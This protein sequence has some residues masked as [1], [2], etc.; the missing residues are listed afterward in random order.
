M[1]TPKLPSVPRR[2]TP[3]LKAVPSSNFNDVLNNSI[4]KLK[5]MEQEYRT[6]T[7]FTDPL[8]NIKVRDYYRRNYDYSLG[9]EVG[10]RVAGTLE[11]AGTGYILGSII[12]SIAMLIAA[13]FTGGATLSSIPS[14]AALGG[15]I[16]AGLGA[17]I[18]AAT[19]DYTTGHATADLIKNN[20]RVY[21][22]Q[23]TGA[24]LLGTLYTVGKSMDIM[25]GGETIRS[26]IYSAVTGTDATENIL[27]SIGLHSSGRKL[28]DFEVIRKELGIDLGGLPNFVIDL[29]G[30]LFT[31]PGFVAQIRV[32]TSGS[33][34]TKQ[35]SSLDLS[36][37][38]KVSKILGTSDSL[39]DLVKLAQK[40]SGIN[41]Q[42]AKALLKSD[43]A[44]LANLMA[45]NEL[46]KKGTKLDIDTIK[47]FIDVARE[48]SF[49]NFTGRIYEVSKAIDSADDKLTG[50]MFNIMIP[51]TLLIRYR[52]PISKLL[53]NGVTLGEAGNMTI[54][55]FFKG[56]SALHKYR[57]QIDRAIMAQQVED[58]K[59]LFS[60]S[61]FYGDINYKDVENHL[62]IMDNPKATIENKKTSKEFLEKAKEELQ[63]EVSSLN[64]SE[65]IKHLNTL[66]NRLA[67]VKSRR[68]HST[69][70]VS[71]LE[72]RI[73]D[74]SGKIKESF[75]KRA[76]LQ[77][78]LSYLDNGLT[79]SKIK[80]SLGRIYNLMGYKHN[81]AMEGK[82][83]KLINEDIKEL[84][85]L[86]N[87]P[88]ASEIVDILASNP[89][90]GDLL[91]Y[92]RDFDSADLDKIRESSLKVL[93][94]AKDAYT[95]ILEKMNKKFLSDMEGPSS[96]Q[97]LILKYTE[98]QKMVNKINKEIIDVID[99]IKNPKKHII[100]AGGKQNPPISTSKNKKILEDLRAQKEEAL[101]NQEEISSAIENLKARLKLI[102]E[103]ETTLYS[104]VRNK[105]LI[106]GVF[107]KDK[108]EAFERQIIS[109]KIYKEHNSV[110]FDI[111][112]KADFAIMNYFEKLLEYDM[113]NLIDDFI[114][115]V[116]IFQPVSQEASQARRVINTSLN[117][118]DSSY[119][120]TTIPAAVLKNIDSM[121]VFVS[122]D[123]PSLIANIE[124]QLKNLQDMILDNK[125]SELS[126]DIFKER[127]KNLSETLEYFK[128]PSPDDL[129]LI[130]NA[131]NSSLYSN[132]PSSILYSSYTL[133][134][135]FTNAES[136]RS[137]LSNLSSVRKKFFWSKEALDV[138]MRSK[139]ALARNIEDIAR[140]KRHVPDKYY[141]LVN[142]LD[143]ILDT[144]FNLN[145]RNKKK[146]ME[147]YTALDDLDYIQLQISVD[148]ML[149]SSEVFLDR[150]ARDIEILQKELDAINFKIDSG[151]ENGFD[152]SNLEKTR[153][154]IVD[155]L[156]DLTDKHHTAAKET[157][158][159]EATLDELL[160]KY[161]EVAKNMSHDQI[162]YLLT[163][164][165]FNKNIDNILEAFE[166][167]DY[168]AGI[169]TY[170]KNLS[171]IFS[172][173]PDDMFYKNLKDST[174][175]LLDIVENFGT[176]KDTQ[177]LSKEIE[178]LVKSTNDIFKYKSKIDFIN[179]ELKLKLEF[180]FEDLDDY[181]QKI[182]VADSSG[183]LPL[184]TKYIKEF[185]NDHGMSRESFL[186]NIL[187][188]PKLR[189]DLEKLP[190]ET[191]EFLVKLD[192]EN[193]GELLN[194]SEFR[195]QA[196][197]E[198]FETKDFVF[199]YTNKSNTGAVLHRRSDSIRARHTLEPTEEA[200]LKT[201]QSELKIKRQD[202][203]QNIKEIEA[204]ISSIKQ[205]KKKKK[206]N[207]TQRL[208][209]EKKAQEYYS[210]VQEFESQLAD[211][212]KQLGNIAE[213]S[214]VQRVAPKYREF[215]IDT[216]TTSKNFNKNGILELAI[217]DANGETLFDIYLDPDDFDKLKDLGF[218]IDQEALDVNGLNRKYLAKMKR[219]AAAEP[220]GPIKSMTLEQMFEFLLN[221]SGIFA[222]DSII[223][224]HNGAFDLG[225]LFSNYVRTTAG[226]SFKNAELFG[227]E[228]LDL[229]KAK[230]L[231]EVFNGNIV[232]TY[233]LYKSY[234]LLDDSFGYAVTS[235]IDSNFEVVTTRYG[236]DAT[237]YLDIPGKIEKRYYYVDDELEIGYFLD[238]RPAHLAEIDNKLL[239]KINALFKA[240][241]E[242]TGIL[243]DFDLLDMYHRYPTNK[244]YKIPD[245]VKKELYQSI[246]PL[247]QEYL[248][249][250]TIESLQDL[251]NVYT[252]L[253]RRKEAVVSNIVYEKFGIYENL[254]EINVNS[255]TVE[256]TKVLEEVEDLY[257]RIGRLLDEHYANNKNISQIILNKKDVVYG[258][259]NQ[260]Y[261]NL[262]MLYQ[263]VLFNSFL[264][265]VKSVLDGTKGGSYAPMAE[266]FK[267]NKSPELQELKDIINEVYESAHWLDDMLGGIV[268]T[269]ES[270]DIFYQAINSAN[271]FLE[272]APKGIPPAHALEHIQFEVYSR[273]FRFGRGQSLSPD[274]LDNIIDRTLEYYSSGKDNI[275][276]F[277]R[278]D[279]SNKLA[280]D[281]KNKMIDVYSMFDVNR[282]V[283]DKNGVQIG[284]EYSPT[285][286]MFYNDVMDML[287][288]FRTPLVEA[289]SYKIFGENGSGGLLNPI[290][291]D[292]FSKDSKMSQS[293]LIA[294]NSKTVLVDSYDMKSSKRAK[295]LSQNPI[296]DL[297]AERDAKGS[298]FGYVDAS[299]T[300]MYQ[301]W[302]K[303]ANTLGVELKTFLNSINFKYNLSTEGG[304]KHQYAL[305]IWDYLV[306]NAD[307][308]SMGV[309][310]L[311]A[312]AFK[313][314]VLDIEVLEI[315]NIEDIS[316]LK[317]R[318]KIAFV[319]EYL[320]LNPLPRSHSF[321]NMSEAMSSSN[322]LLSSI[323]HIYNTPELLKGY[324]KSSPH[325]A[326]VMA[327]PKLVNGKDG[328]VF[329]NYVYRKIDTGDIESLSNALTDLKGN[330]NTFG[331]MSNDSFVSL[332]NDVGQK[333][334]MPEWLVAVHNRL[335]Y[336][337]K[338]FSLLFSAPFVVTNVTAAFIQN[339]SVNGFNPIKTIASLS[340]TSK[341]YHLWKELFEGIFGIEGL[342]KH[343]SG[344]RKFN[345]SWFDLLKSRDKEFMEL[346][347]KYDSDL[348]T[349]IK[350]IS[351]KDMA[352]IVELNSIVNTNASLG[353]LNEVQRNKDLSDKMD[354]RYIEVKESATNGD[355][356]A[357]EEFRVLNKEPNEGFNSLEDE[358]EDLLTKRRNKLLT[359][360]NDFR[361]INILKR[362]IKE[363][364][365]SLMS[366]VYKLKFLNWWSSFNSDIETIFRASMIKESLEVGD[367]LGEATQLV[368]DRHFIYN[369]KSLFEKV[370][371]VIIPF[372]SY[373]MKAAALFTDL[374]SD[375]GFSKLMYEFLDNSWGDND[376]NLK[377]N[378][379]LNRKSKGDIPIGDRLYSFGNPMTEALSSILNPIEA[380]DN[381]LNPLAKPFVDL[382]KDAKYNRVSQLPVVSQTT[383][384]GRAIQDSDTNGKFYLSQAL[385]LSKSYFRRQN[386]YYTRSSYPG[387]SYLYKNLYTSGGHSR[388]QMR[389][390]NTNIN[391]VRYRV[392]DILF[393]NRMRM[394]NK[395]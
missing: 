17:T 75:T 103:E 222:S 142:K 347:E 81:A 376:D 388:V 97:D 201:L 181:K 164:A 173:L 218:D 92:I 357:Q 248:D 244:S 67:H 208:R 9:A 326:L 166:N 156:R 131:P 145:P 84:Y 225:A 68:K 100:N 313:K 331:L 44:K 130:Q 8:A 308:N 79:V 198:D 116:E 374:T 49:N 292:S 179:N 18:G 306:K 338:F 83:K 184:L 191:K 385:G 227:S 360:R 56:N 27:K 73:K 1:N 112:K 256:T 59:K 185:V 85:T 158:T 87:D 369:D 161:P 77:G 365:P 172:L 110:S 238:G 270:V 80:K 148:K 249:G 132:F 209:L 105:E 324:F 251:Y 10:G 106:A 169:H 21:K 245:V 247:M 163:R 299:E 279:L 350:N 66:Q 329:L 178:N 258:R 243:N 352:R 377:N 159:L 194:T 133:D 327:E 379:L 167:G 228:N 90:Y 62:E 373:P 213:T 43:D 371:E 319:S 20:I 277:T 266:Y 305:S 359:E 70:A 33:K 129:K 121:P 389:M 295:S 108:I 354:K 171:P 51:Q 30:D 152:V 19:S 176:H 344:T 128:G 71:N 118:L 143:N 284:V 239:Y 193:G 322:S 89:T 57:K 346:L 345:E 283:L 78:K 367:S 263:G 236:K 47:K 14:A 280:L 281:I 26:T 104:D 275:I 150:T 42:L 216:E 197:L 314:L 199:E 269:P 165:S 96:E 259:L 155:N 162:L 182:N 328:R 189:I 285:L 54:G 278:K 170:V 109:D 120:N 356:N 332:V 48:E 28:Y 233:Q 224:A 22:E 37:N 250:E 304:K 241:L 123:F 272:I 370:A 40:D 293:D 211:I 323:S 113:E 386:S 221:K 151:I 288:Q 157:T 202:S 384:V 310:K 395:R 271:T 372:A 220:D 353:Q 207:V 339:L 366:K 235:L 46:L 267:N 355:V 177:R 253:Y 98:N 2:Y 231:F 230:D 64:I 212:E 320:Q 210:E 394:N 226:S 144:I 126:K 237:E 255:A 378:Y 337:I 381:K 307:N 200:S 391:N 260:N 341:D 5:I 137:A 74:L 300:K 282:K 254:K 53:I 115:F 93:Q 168:V 35:F 6:P 101:R 364:S 195:G 187:K 72:S 368:T 114:K 111:N 76:E 242:S 141:E 38:A 214:H 135:F 301:M 160:K 147:L 265:D 24:G 390:S 39:N 291:L 287:D 343:Y 32:F 316:E 63:Q 325:M 229:T 361:R 88:K 358:L 309:E 34:L 146:I 348:Y 15:K 342:V 217:N 240:R 125:Y 12:G 302:Q 333:V 262:K 336:P 86:L 11:G 252:K 392:G 69:K 180:S 383:Q 298:F 95:D 334:E 149:I 117:I 387:R 140:Y 286:Q 25:G 124:N 268:D 318:I 58:S 363:G 205:I 290:S 349:K 264:Y 257:D 41:K 192:L 55:E 91:K 294:K 13:P 317:N 7:V 219:K 4:Y 215:Y 382:A 315:T 127:H 107:S 50:I 297:Y 99:T 23:G 203:L 188:D 276:M 321:Y 234:A 273:M 380:I 139:R 190:K 61:K 335:I 196:L 311:D 65:D 3:N 204:T 136:A 153:R 45:S 82:V 246:S 303:V 154:N 16:G 174:A 119:K 206:S 261:V 102:R 330:K 312:E 274:I 183:G 232:D 340:Q 393:Q 223:Y 296:K 138:L 375:Y 351:D 289:K 186:N 60:N 134:D 29:L 31:D 36:R 362:H 122:S 175:K 94:N 52:R